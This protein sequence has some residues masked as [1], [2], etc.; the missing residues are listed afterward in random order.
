MRL[1]SHGHP[2]KITHR[3]DLARFLYDSLPDSAKARISTKK[4]VVGV[5]VSEEGVRVTCDDGS[6]HEGSIIIGADGVRSTIRQ[7]VQAHRLGKQPKDLPFELKNPYVTTYRLYFGTLSHRPSGLEPSVRWDGTSDDMCTQII[8]G[9]NRIWYGVYE[10]LES[11][12]SEH[13]RYTEADK[14]EILRKWGDLYV[15]PGWKVR[16]IDAIRDGDSGLIDLEEGLVDTWFWKRIVLVGDAVRKMEPHA[17]LGYNCGIMDIVALTNALRQ[18]LVKSSG[19]APSTQELET[20]FGR[21]QADRAQE[22]KQGAKLSARAIRYLAWPTWKE[23]FMSMYAM[24]YLPLTRMAANNDIA[25]FISGAAVLEWL[26]EKELPPSGKPW[27]HHPFQNKGP[28]DSKEP[29]LGPS[30]AVALLSSALFVVT[31]GVYWRR[32]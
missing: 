2:V 20:L 23:R 32:S 12:T 15:C 28:A 26:D 4:H 24:P 17:G 5:D 19:D 30:Y 27:K 8:V 22:T 25:P 13:R 18:Q 31:L 29:H 16:D 3:P 10:K 11:P 7:H 21:Y 9:T 6:V 14:A 1:S